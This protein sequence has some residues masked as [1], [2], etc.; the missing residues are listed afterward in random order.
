[1]PR[2]DRT[3]RGGAVRR[4][5]RERIVSGLTVGVVRLRASFSGDGTASFSGGGPSSFY[6]GGPPRFP[7][8]GHRSFGYS[9]NGFARPRGRTNMNPLSEYR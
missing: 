9:V 6:V 3:R 8:A 1:M 4:R 2:A 5:L 7:A